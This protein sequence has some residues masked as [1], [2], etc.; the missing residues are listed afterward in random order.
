M[1]NDDDSIAEGM[2]FDDTVCDDCMSCV[3]DDICGKVSCDGNSVH[4]KVGVGDD[5]NDIDNDDVGDDKF[6][7][8]ATTLLRRRR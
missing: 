5:D 8:S 6:V 2:A 1:F 3:D 4:D 7:T